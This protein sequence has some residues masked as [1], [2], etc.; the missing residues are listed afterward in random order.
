MNVIPEESLNTVSDVHDTIEVLALLCD[1]LTPEQ[2][3]LDA[4]QLGSMFH[5]LARCLGEAAD[6]VQVRPDTPLPHG[7]KMAA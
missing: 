2:V 6:Q 1:Q 7:P 5:F 4:A 3:A